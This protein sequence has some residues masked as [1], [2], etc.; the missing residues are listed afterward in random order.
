MRSV[1]VFGAAFLLS[2]VFVY[3]IRRWAERKSILD[4]PNERSSHDVP[5]PRGGGI[6]IVAITLAGSAWWWT[7][8]F[9]AVG[10]AALVIAIVSWIDDVRHLPATLHLA[11]QSLCAIAVLIAYPTGAFAP[12][13]FLWIVGLTN[14]YNFMDGIDGIAGGQAVVAGVAWALIGMITHQPL[15][16]MLG[17]LIAGA[18]AGFL[19]HKWQPARIFM[20]DVGSAFLGFLV[21]ALAVMAWPNLRMAAAGVLV[22]WP[23]VADAAFTF[24]RRALRGERVMEAHRSHLYQRMN[25]RGL[26]HAAVS[27]IYVALAAVGAVAAVALMRAV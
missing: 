10:A 27:L 16:A 25:Q 9:A 19:M 23:F 20:G 11:V 22:V 8:R 4:H 14:A 12:L 13:A 2:A 21:A 3:V 18:S 15:A 26:S 6:A 5:K 7:P 17:L 1:V 24:V